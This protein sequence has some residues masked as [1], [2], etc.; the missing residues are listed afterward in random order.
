MYAHTQ[1]PQMGF[2]SREKPACKKEPF[3]EDP[4]VPE[5]ALGLDSMLG[6]T[7]VSSYCVTLA[8]SARLTSLSLCF[9]ISKMG[10]RATSLSGLW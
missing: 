10:T 5:L 1:E 2:L 9:L 8:K 6:I 3:G 4:I 7:P